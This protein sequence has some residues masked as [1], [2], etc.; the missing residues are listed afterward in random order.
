M[1][2]EH[3]EVRAL[4]V[5]DSASSR[6]LIRHHL[7]NCGCRVVAEAGNPAQALRAYELLSTFES[8]RP[9][10]ITL[11]IVMPHVDGIDALTLFRMFKKHDPSLPILIVSAVPFPKAREAFLSE[12]A[13]DYMVKPF[14]KFYFENVRRKL[15]H[16][17]PQIA[18]YANRSGSI[19]AR[20]D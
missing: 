16:V 2:K 18:P 13:L 15:E 19:W 8:S 12:G 9:N 6:Q 17:F 4:I 10:F 20:N 14:N 1:H 5:D 3:M 7:E 11:D